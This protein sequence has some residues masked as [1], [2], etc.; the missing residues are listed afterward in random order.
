MLSR[1][2][3]PEAV[4]AGG[5]GAT[6][7]VTL[8]MDQTILRQLELLRSRQVSPPE[9]VE[10]ALRAIERVDPGVRAWVTVAGER[11]LAQA[12]EVAQG[13]GRPLA[14]VPVAIKD[15]SALTEGI[16]TTMGSSA[17]GDW[18][19]RED[20]AT[21]RRL[22]A[23]GAIVIGK[24]NTSE[25]G[26]VALT[27]PERF[28]PTRNPWDPVRSPGGSS[29]GSA[30]AVASG[31]VAFAHGSDG[32]GSIRVPAS[33]CG[34]V[35]LK[36]SRGRISSAPGPGDPLG[37]A[38]EGVLAR[39][40]A[41]VALALDVMAGTEP[42]D[43]WLAWPPDGGSFAAAV[44]RAPG[45]LRVAVSAR[46]PT[47]VGVHP[48]CVAA[49]TR[50]GAALEA[51]GHRVIEDAP[52]WVHPEFM[53]RFVAHWTAGVGPA[54]EA[55]GALIGRP[56]DPARLEP[57]TRAIIAEAAPTSL[58]DYLANFGWLRS[59]ARRVVAFWE[60]FDVFVTPS[61]AQPPPLIGSLAAPPGDSPTRQ[62]W[63]VA[64]VVPFTPPLNVTGQPALSVPLHTSADGL[65]IG[66][67]L[68]GPPNGEALLLSVAAQ[69]ERAEPWAE[70]TPALVAR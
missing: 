1:R 61:M 17:L 67:Q 42:G 22:R 3:A 49:L 36:P 39:T 9:L 13:D 63:T 40:V 10:D 51:L 60:R 43:P 16:R 35:G 26:I 19:P 54:V 29:G 62:L 11:A 23:A 45:S 69:L 65:P 52:A 58:A 27:E 7:S 12:G 25:L 30:A 44:A 6:P 66:V 33:C 31:T 53:E 21:V 59:Y 2:L 38:T 46:A 14:G 5:S 64:D 41:D 18:V 70:R 48:D 68:V 56:L 55:I 20:S 34:L 50:A 47:E 15:L 4:D 37:L 57:L 24:T 32:G 8:D 28:G